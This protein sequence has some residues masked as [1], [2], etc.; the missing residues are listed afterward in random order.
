MASKY[1]YQAEVRHDGL[2]K[3]KVVKAESNYQL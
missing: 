1:Y 3:Y 2:G